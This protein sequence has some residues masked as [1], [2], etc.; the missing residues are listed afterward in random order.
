[1]TLTKLGE[2]IAASMQASPGLL[3]LTVTNLV[4]VG[5]V[6]LLGSAALSAYDDQQKAIERRYE[7]VIEMLDRCIDTRKGPQ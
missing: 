3:F 1:M 4:F 2:T 7:H 6:Y 5:F